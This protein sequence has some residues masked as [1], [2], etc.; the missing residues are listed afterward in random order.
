MANRF[1]LIF[2]NVDASYEY[3]G[4]STIHWF[5]IVNIFENDPDDTRVVDWECNVHQNDV[6]SIN[7]KCDIT[8]KFAYSAGG[9]GT[10]EFIGYD[11]GDANSHQQNRAIKLFHM[12]FTRQNF[13]PGEIQSLPVDAYN[14]RFGT[15][16][17]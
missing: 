17:G 1:I 7:I 5:D 13:Q 4:S 6:S 3:D 12:A 15:N 10:E 14:Q 2:G 11:G 8:S 9:P 16:H